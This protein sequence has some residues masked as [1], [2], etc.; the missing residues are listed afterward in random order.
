MQKFTQKYIIA[1]FIEEQQD[2]YT[3][4]MEDW[5]LHVTLA[6]VFAID[7]NANELI[8][9]LGKQLGSYPVSQAKVIADALFGE[10]KDIPVRLVDRTKDLLDLHYEIVSA[11]KDYGVQFNNP[12]F[13]NEGFGPHATIQKNDRLEVGDSV[14]FD[15]V[16]LVDMFPEQDPYQRKILGTVYF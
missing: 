14:K 11:L 3:F 9:S 2:G 8:G 10:N 4:S 16:T 13:A 7:G 12:E 5:P 6:G 15:S 1:H